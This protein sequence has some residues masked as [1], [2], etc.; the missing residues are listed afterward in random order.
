MNNIFLNQNIG[1]LA[2][3]YKTPFFLF[4]ERELTSNYRD[5]LKSFSRYYTKVRIDYS[6]KTN[7]EIGVLRVLKNAGSNAEIVSGY[8]L[9]LCK[10]AGFKLNKLTFD[11]PYKT[12]EDIALAIKSGIH[13][14]YADSEGE[15]ERIDRVASRY[16]KIVNVG[17]RVNLGMKSY[18]EG[19]AE[20]YI[21]KFGE[22]YKKVKDILM[23]NS[24][25]KNIRIMAISTHIG[26]QILKPEY[27]VKA[28]EMMLILAKE[29]YDS[30][31]KLE[32]VCLGGGFPSQ[33]LIKNTLPR[34]L[35]S[36]IGMRFVEKPKPISEYGN[37]IA[38]AF[39]KLILAN[40]LPK[41]TLVLQPGRSIS[42]SM[43]IM[44]TKA[45]VVKDNWVFL[46]T[47]TSSLPESIFFAQ[48]KIVPFIKEKRPTKK[49]NIAGK[50]L[51]SSDN[52]VIDEVFPLIKKGDLFA[53]LDAGAYSISRANRFTTLNPPVYMIKTSGNIV[54]IRRDENY[55]DVLGPME[56]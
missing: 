36:Q 42:S 52:F 56:F 38:T 25:L 29:I 27:Y 28:V 20:T 31:I 9:E 16:R 23:R 50:G 35:L 37:K 54:R 18:L 48:R 14:F 2:K 34:L 5:L 7:N 3:K 46:D 15:F 11:G 19:P 8:E 32:E 49:Y 24:G 51:N 30:G 40:D 55:K 12:D 13:A 26:S 1:E 45:A 44:I 43:G 6:V 17:L 4:S 39:S 53:I 47:S 10:K 22:D 33:T 41:M 21:T